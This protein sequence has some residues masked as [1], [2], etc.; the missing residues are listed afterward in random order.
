M[1]KNGIFNRFIMKSRNADK[2]FIIVKNRDAIND[3]QNVL[4]N[5]KITCERE[6]RTIK[7][8]ILLL[9]Q[10]NKKLGGI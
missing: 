1:I 7:D 6:E 5:K 10:I 9:Q 3:L 2:K 4:A 8:M